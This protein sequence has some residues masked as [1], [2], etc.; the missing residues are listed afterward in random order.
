MSKFASPDRQAASVMK[1][2]QGH[3]LSS[4]RTVANYEACLSLVAK[5]VQANRLGSL[6]DLT[7]GMALTWLEKRS[8][9]VTAASGTKTGHGQRC[10]LQ[11][12]L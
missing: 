4:V 10:V 3:T 5:Y 11:E 7:P 6:R 1:A 12:L 9:S 8:L 2:L